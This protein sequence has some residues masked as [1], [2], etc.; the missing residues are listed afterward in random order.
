[1]LCYNR[2]SRLATS[3]CVMLSQ[4]NGYSNTV[5]SS[6]QAWESFSRIWMRRTVPTAHRT[7]SVTYKNSM[8]WGKRWARTRVCNVSGVHAIVGVGWGQCC[9]PM[10]SYPRRWSEPWSSWPWK[11]RLKRK[12]TGSKRSISPTR[13]VKQ[14]QV[15]RTAY[16]TYP[17]SQFFGFSLTFNYAR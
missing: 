15:K 7:S 5:S 10:S 14:H 9:G 4:A 17:K 3:A 16:M 2:T 6:T 8:A 1:M 11:G 12:Y 13:L